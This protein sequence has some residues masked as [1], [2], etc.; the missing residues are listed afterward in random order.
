M[1]HEI[2]FAIFFLAMIAAPA[3]V[4]DLSGPNNR[5]SFWFNRAL[6]SPRLSTVVCQHRTASRTT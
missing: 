3:F 4:S 2:L 6:S 5:D 1:F